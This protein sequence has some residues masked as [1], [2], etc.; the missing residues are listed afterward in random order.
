[1]DIVID[2]ILREASDII[3]FPDDGKSERMFLKNGMVEI[4][5]DQ[6]VGIVLDIF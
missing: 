5:M 2:I 4:I 1:M 3:R 6:V